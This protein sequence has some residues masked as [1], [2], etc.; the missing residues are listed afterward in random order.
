MVKTLK[1]SLHWKRAIDWELKK[2]VQNLNDCPRVLKRCFEYALFPGGKRLRPLLCL[3]SYSTSGG[4]SIKEALPFACALELIHTFSLIHD[5]L[6]A[7]DNDNFRRGK[8]TLHKVFGEDLAILAGDALLVLSFEI[9]FQELK[10]TA[11]RAR[12]EE[13]RRQ[14]FA[15]TE[16]GKAI[17]NQGLV[18]GEVRDVL[19]KSQTTK[20]KLKNY[21][22]LIKKK[23]AS[24]IRSSL[25]VGGLL[26]GLEKKRLNL[27]AQGGENLGILFQLIDDLADRNGAVPLFGEKVI[28]QKRTLYAQRALRSFQK[29]GKNFALFSE[30]VERINSGKTI[31]ADDE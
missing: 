22:S 26:A 23:T 4:K 31:F 11:E 16:I 7:I 2:I 30:I 12:F 27:L 24:L 29:L 21:I 8:P 25:V 5:D 13:C 19:L 18:N 10:K 14:C 28:W 17:G 20:L 6:P 9:L 3:F 15:L 1:D